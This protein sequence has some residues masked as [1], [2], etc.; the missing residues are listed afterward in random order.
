MKRIVLSAK[1]GVRAH[2][3]ERPPQVADKLDIRV[4]GGVKTVIDVIT[5]LVNV[6]NADMELLAGVQYEVVSVRE[7]WVPWNITT[8]RNKVR[9]IVEAQKQ[10][11]AID[12]RFSRRESVCSFRFI[13]SVED[14]FAVGAS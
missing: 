13:V 12:I 11:V 9:I 8:I 10:N 2:E 6:R 3:K 7:K 4:S 5:V 14:P 1:R